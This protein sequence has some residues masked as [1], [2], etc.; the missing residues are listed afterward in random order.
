M[1]PACLLQSRDRSILAGRTFQRGVRRRDQGAGPVKA[2]EGLI[3]LIEPKG[4]SGV[5][6][7]ALVEATEADREPAQRPDRLVR[8][9]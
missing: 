2:A 3:S 7:Y 1:L 6:R 9:A 5:V 4:G 8:E